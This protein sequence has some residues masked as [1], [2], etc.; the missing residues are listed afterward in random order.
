MKPIF[1]VIIG[2][3]IGIALLCI[4]F[5]VVSLRTPSTFGTWQFRMI[6]NNRVLFNSAGD[7]TNSNAEFML[8]NYSC[9]IGEDQT[10]MYYDL[11]FNPQP[12]MNKDIFIYF[13]D[14]VDNKIFFS[15][16]DFQKNGSI[17]LYKKGINMEILKHKKMTGVFTPRN[18]KTPVTLS[19]DLTLGDQ[20]YQSL[21]TMCA[22]GK[23][24]E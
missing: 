18:S 20:A 19:I 15:F 12:N 16:T 4:T 22:L 6:T 5:F 21:H 23:R 2:V 3:V 8:I 11:G 7:I 13:D 24:I 17:D 1:K 9:Y 14:N 10:I